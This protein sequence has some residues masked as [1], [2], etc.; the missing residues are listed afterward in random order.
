MS[1]YK[2]KTKQDLAKAL[3][4][5]RAALQAFH[6]ALSGSKAKNVKEGRLLRKEIA[7][8]MTEQNAQHRAEVKTA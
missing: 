5:K 4:D 1:D 2:G 6:F 3:A 7:R 8:I